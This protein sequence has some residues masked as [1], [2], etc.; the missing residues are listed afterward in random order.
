[1]MRVP[2]VSTIGSLMYAMVCMRP[3]IAHAIGVVRRYMSC[4]RKL[5]W[6]AVKWIVRYLLGTKGKCLELGRGSMEV[7]MYIDADM[8]GDLDRRKSTTGYVYT[9]GGTIVS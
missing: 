6:D 7:H 3:D 1:M 5:Y 9:F 8:G 4:P 2:Y